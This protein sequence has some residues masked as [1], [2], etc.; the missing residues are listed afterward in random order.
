[1]QDP[2]PIPGSGRSPVGGN[3]VTSPVF[4]L[5]KSHGHRSLAGYSPWGHKESDLTWRLNNENLHL[6]LQ[7]YT[8]FPT[9]GISHVNILVR[10]WDHLS[11][12]R[13]K[14][15]FLNISPGGHGTR[16]LQSHGLQIRTQWNGKNWDHGIWSHYFMANRWG[17]SGNSETLF[18]GAPK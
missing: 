11:L 4:L 14:A 2:G 15:S 10:V 13:R 16:F 9:E 1:M 7:I 18:F 12:W 3:G 5:G 8:H 17:N 6:Y